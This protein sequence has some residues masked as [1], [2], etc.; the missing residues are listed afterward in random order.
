M[1]ETFHLEICAVV[2][3]ADESILNINLDNGFSFCKKSLIPDKDHLDVILERD[4]ISLR[5]DYESARIDNETLDVICLYKLCD[6]SLA[7]T[8]AKL[9]FDKL[10]DE[11]SQ[12]L[13]DIIRKLRLF[14]EASLMFKRLAISLKSEKK[15]IGETMVSSN[16]NAIIPIGEALASKIIKKFSCTNEEANVLQE[17]IKSLSLP[18]EEP[19]INSSFRYYDLSYHED[20][21][22]SITLLI[23]ALEI[24]F[25]SKK[26]RVDKKKCLAK[27]ISVFLFTD[28]DNILNCYSNIKRLYKKRSDFVHDG[29]TSK[30]YDEDILLLRDY[31]RKCILKLNSTNFDKA[32]LIRD[33]KDKVSKMTYWEEVE[34][35]ND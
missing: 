20:N 2:F 35:D 10:R 34:T 33:L 27:R 21:F 26:N 16:Y 31:T 13:D 5:R 30:I 23:T 15:Q 25:L 28:K 29:V 14:K 6:I 4:A 9:I 24:L 22:I 18:F 1:S 3:G 19:V 11:S 8:D 17:N 12:Y 32:K 7:P